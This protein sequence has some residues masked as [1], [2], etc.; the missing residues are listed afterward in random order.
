MS[1]GQLGHVTIEAPQHQIIV[2]LAHQSSPL[3]SISFVGQPSSMFNIGL[4][5]Q[6]AGQAWHRFRV[7]D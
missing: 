5:R 7:S 2:G 3:H 6:L 4:L 1:P